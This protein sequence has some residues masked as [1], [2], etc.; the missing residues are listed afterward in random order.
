MLT[1]PLII[2]VD[3]RNLSQLTD[4]LQENG[5]SDRYDLITKNSNAKKDENS[6]L[7]DYGYS[8]STLNW[9]KE[10]IDQEKTALVI[11]DDYED[12]PVI[13]EILNSYGYEIIDT[14]EG[15]SPLFQSYNLEITHRNN[16][17]LEHNDERNEVC[18]E[19]EDFD[20]QIQVPIPAHFVQDPYEDQI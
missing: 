1:Q 12:L 19:D 13:F 10:Q 6:S 15:E 17:A 20:E 2:L 3:N 9:L 8:L 5:L 7:E 4:V 16:L 14:Y 18:I 11:Y